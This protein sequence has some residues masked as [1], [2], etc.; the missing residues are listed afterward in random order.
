MH[1]RRVRAEVKTSGGLARNKTTTEVRVILS[2]FGPKGVGIFSGQPLEIGQE[3]SLTLEDPKR[4]YV[5]GRVIA[6][7]E[8]DA[9]SHVISKMPYSYRIGVQFLFESAEEESQVKAFCEMI[10]KDYVFSQGA[11]HPQAERKE[12]AA[13]EE[14][15]E[16]TAE[17]ADPIKQAA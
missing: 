7:L 1:I 17:G 13:S 14:E 4:F 3:I 6:C 8:H 16:A 10:H 15:A 12:A 2:D 11:E 9:G 5:K